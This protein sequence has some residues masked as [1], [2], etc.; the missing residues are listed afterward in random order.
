MLY[1]KYRPTKLSQMILPDGV[2]VLIRKGVSGDSLPRCL[3]IFGPPGCGKTT[4]AYVIKRMLKAELT[5]INSAN[6]R[7][8]DTVRELNEVLESESLFSSPRVIILDEAHQITKDAQH[9]LLK[10][11]E[12]VSARDF[13]KRVYFCILTPY[14]EKLIKELRQRCLVIN[15]TLVSEEGIRTILSSIAEKEEVAT[16]DKDLDRIASI[17]EGSVRS[18]IVYLQSFIAGYKSE[19]VVDVEVVNNAVPILA[20]AIM[21]RNVGTIIKTCGTIQSKDVF[22]ASQGVVGYLWACLKGSQNE[23]VQ[24]AT[25]SAIKAIS[26]F[27]SLPPLPLGEARLAAFL[28]T[29]L[30]TRSQTK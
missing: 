2:A 21:G 10:T 25:A 30:Q 15:L 11:V 5:E 6:F 16:E 29:A 18:A 22:S 14:P 13:K 9:A 7:G 20:K 3:G 24:T 26:E 28:T 8:I 1:N 27:Q 4:L 12:S 19:I 23:S 17:A